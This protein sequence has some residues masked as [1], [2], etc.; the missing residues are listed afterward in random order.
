MGEETSS[1]K[2]YK[3][4][5]ISLIVIAVMIAGFFIAS[6]LLKKDD[7]GT[8]AVPTLQE[9]KTVR[10][11]NFNSVSQVQAYECNIVDDITLERQGEKEWVCPTY[12]DI[13]L[14][15]TGINTALNSVRACMASVV[16]EGEITEEII[17]NYDISRTEYIKVTLKD[18]TVYTLRFGMQKPGVAMFFAIVEEQEKVYLI[19]STYKDSLILTKEDLLY[20]KIFDFK[21][22]GKIKDMEV[23]KKGEQFLSLSSTFT[24]DS[25]TWTMT[26]PLSRQG[27]DTYI[28]DVINA[29]STLY[30]SEY[31][32]G[33]CKDLAKYG[34]DNP[35]YTIKLTDN[36]GQQTLSL[37]NKVPEGGAFYCIFGDGTNVFTVSMQSVA[38]TD[39]PVIKYLKPE[40]FTRMYTELKEIKA[41]ITCGDIK[42]TF[43]LGF[44]IWEDGEQLYFNSQPITDSS[45]IKAF[46]RVNTALYSLDLVGLEEEPAEKGELL[47]KITYTMAKD[48]EVV[49]VEGYRA[50]ETTMH[51]YENGKYC[52]GYDYIRQITGDN[53]SYGIMGTLENFKTISGIK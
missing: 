2:Q 36:K 51:L 34:L 30:T 53:N 11:F 7:S 46:R 25:R 19:N 22:K 49:V 16:Y 6:S 33:D 39:D 18:G 17:K 23:F 42:E 44:D 38:F 45:A 41:E 20:T 10:V 3:T 9:E 37:G 13:D 24:E 29:V 8:T 21:D 47:I 50:D 15:T 32:E 12:T 31:I 4:T 35:A 26:Y 52:G 14:Y 1:M 48:G 28:E 27:K 43:K 5:I 40:I